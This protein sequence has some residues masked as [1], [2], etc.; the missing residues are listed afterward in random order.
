MLIEG[1]G[2]AGVGAVIGL[3]N[4]RVAEMLEAPVVIVSEGAAG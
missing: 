4:A 2:H 3:S 1:T